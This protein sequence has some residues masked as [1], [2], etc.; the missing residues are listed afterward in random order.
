ML[1]VLSEFES[2]LIT[3]TVL[4]KR[5]GDR[6]FVSKEYKKFF[7]D[8]DDRI[9]WDIPCIVTFNTALKNGLIV[10][11]GKEDFVGNCRRYYY[12]V[13]NDYQKEV[14]NK[15]MSLTENVHNLNQETLNL[16]KRI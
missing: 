4:Q 9:T 5:F 16:L 1:R 6:E 10:K 12:K 15:L 11:T 13:N 8:Y 14:Y 2:K 3:L 7:R